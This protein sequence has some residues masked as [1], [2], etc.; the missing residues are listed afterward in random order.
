MVAAAE[1]AHNSSMETRNYKPCRN[2]AKGAK[3]CSRRFR[4]WQQWS[5]EPHCNTTKCSLKLAAA[6]EEA[7]A[8]KEVVVA[9]V[10]TLHKSQYRCY[11]QHQGSN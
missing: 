8:P 11:I 1:V 3:G 7:A 2:Y 5:L 9:G 10:T 6:A 4:S